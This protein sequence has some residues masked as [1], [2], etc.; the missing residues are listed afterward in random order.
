MTDLNTLTP[1]NS[2]LYLLSADDLNDCRDGKPDMATASYGGP[3]VTVLLNE[4]LPYG[5]QTRAK[6]KHGSMGVK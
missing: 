4:T 6:Q 2:I 1:A 3:N 5:A